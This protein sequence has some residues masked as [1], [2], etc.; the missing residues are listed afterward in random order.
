[1]WG[2]I[3][4]AIDAD[5][6][7]DE[8]ALAEIEEETGLSGDDIELVRAGEP[9]V[10]GDESLGLKKIVY[11]YLFHVKDPSKIRIDWEHKQMKWIKPG[12]IDRYET[13]PKLKE[14]LARV[15]PHSG[16]NEKS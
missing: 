15:M 1:V 2:G 11:P 13:M 12:E 9:V 5:K 7:G 16:A 14:T 6:T 8:Q 3:S 4:G 10:F